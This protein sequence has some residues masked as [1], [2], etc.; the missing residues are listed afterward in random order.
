M[1]FLG[2]LAIYI[3]AILFRQCH[4]KIMRKCTAFLANGF[5]TIRGRI[6]SENY[7]KPETP[8]RLEA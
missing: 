7:P 2:H 5:G 3:G 6:A 8:A 1:T 4:I